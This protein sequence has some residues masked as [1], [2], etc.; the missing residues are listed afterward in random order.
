M[1]S[2]KRSFDEHKV[3][4]HLIHY[5]PAQNPLKDFV[6]HNT[7]HAFQNK[8][9]HEALEEA[10][11]IFG[12]KT[13][14][15]LADF[16]RRFANSEIKESVLDRILIQSKGEENLD[17]WKGKL[18]ENYYDESVNARIGSLRANWKKEYA[19]NLEKSTHSLLFRVLCSYLDQGIAIW[20]FPVHENG[21]L[22]SIRTLENNCFKGIFTSKRAVELLQKDPSI[23]ELLD[24]VVGKEVLFE[25][26]LFDQQFSHPGWSGMIAT[27]ESNPSSLLDSRAI[28]FEELV[29]FE[30]LLEIDALD[31]KFNGNWSPLGL[32]VRENEYNLFEKVKHTELLEV[33][34]L[35]QQAF[36]WSFYDNVLVNV[37]HVEETQ[38]SNIP[39]F[40]GLFCMD[41]RECSF[42]RHIE[43][44]DKEAETFGTAAFFNFEFYFQPVDGKFYTK[45]CPAPITPKYLIIEV[46]RKNKQAKD[47]L[48]HKQTHS[49]LFGW[50]ISQTLGFSS[51]FKLF[52][53]I[54]KPSMSPATTSSFK[55]LHKKAKLVVENTNVN[56]REDN[57]QLGF[58]I[59]E[60]A[61]RMEGLLKSIGLVKNFAPLVYIVGHGAT[62]VNN[63][64]Y[65]GYD[66]GACCG[67]PS[68]VNAK[69]AKMAANH[70]KVREL[71]KLRGINIPETTQ[72]LPALHD[73]TRDEIVFYDEDILTPENQKLHRQNESVFLK[74]LANN[75]KERSRRFDTI[76]SSL[77]LKNVHEKVKR[78]S[79][80]LFEPRPELNHAT[81]AMCIVGRRNLSKQLFLDRRSFLNSYD[82]KV[83]PTG[84]YLSII[85][86]AVAP[87]AG[88]INLEYYFSRVDNQKLGA[89]S[90][91][92]HNVMGLIGV[93]NG[94]DGDLRPGL[95][96]QMI[97]VHDPLRILVVAEHFP[98]KVKYAINKNSLT[99]EWFKND[100]VKLIA[101]QPETKEVFEFK[102]EEFVA[103]KTVQEKAQF[104]K[105]ELDLA[106][107]TNEN[108]PIGILINIY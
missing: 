69:V 52:L 28:T 43:H 86:G 34:S 38:S 14:L 100:W 36:E 90:K 56:Q 82:Y 102:N 105:S 60:M 67:R 44:L 4:H 68:S 75:A 99:Y 87:V 17:F 93:A 47:L 104:I 12:Y 31:G 97:E 33:L 35:W 32:K 30:L 88:G 54:F 7:L 6:H 74:A 27:I 41:D 45:L 49:L 55:H 84:D 42:R 3:L 25:Q 21:F 29:K 10:T 65:A 73:T 15:S 89:G 76:D 19:I 5:L 101:I 95:P 83:D 79:L 39:S 57:L 58:T 77:S 107:T 23:T 62:S 22:A 98:D 108:L 1:K 106:S 9:F 20:N 70:P 59:E 51:A 16:R 50:I 71:L 24:I 91:L 66:C 11:T 63:T 13:Y 94:I 48:Y 103:Y 96:L 8:N 85:L 40:Q 92:P 81:N 53:N 37:Q 72:F 64:H 18:I 26:Y 46:Q 78:R 61:D 80:S 2:T